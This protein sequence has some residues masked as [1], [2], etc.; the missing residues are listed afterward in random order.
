MERCSKAFA[1]IGIILHA[2]VYPSHYK[3]RLTLL[4]GTML[5]ARQLLPP[6]KGAKR[7]D[8]VAEPHIQIADPEEERNAT[9]I[10]GWQ[11]IELA[12]EC[13]QFGSERH[14]IQWDRV[15]AIGRRP[16]R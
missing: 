10:F 4:F 15:I 11:C 8:I 1:G 13:L 6:F 2:N 7:T 3:K 16:Y 14:P 12:P 5:F 9:I